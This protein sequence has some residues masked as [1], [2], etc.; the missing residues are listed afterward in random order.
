[1]SDLTGNVRLRHARITNS[2]VLQ[3]EYVVVRFDGDD[4]YD[5]KVWRDAKPADLQ[6]LGPITT[7]NAPKSNGEA[8]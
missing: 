6:E 2:L 1:M 7:L 5:C 8:R 4:V 3:A